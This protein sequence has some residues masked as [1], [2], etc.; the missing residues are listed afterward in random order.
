ME[1][2]TVLLIFLFELKISEL[3]VQSMH[4][5]SEKNFCE[6][7]LSENDFEIVLATFCWQFRRSLQIRK[8]IASA[9]HV[10]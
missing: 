7:L 9:R 10:L 4:R 3:T 5:N 2:R 6:E 1:T 8:S